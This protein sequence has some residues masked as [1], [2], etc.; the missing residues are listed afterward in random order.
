VSWKRELGLKSTKNAIFWDVAPCVGLV[1][2]DVS[3]ERVTSISRSK[4]IGQLTDYFHPED[5]SNT[6]L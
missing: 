4:G 1:T 6:F 2:S 5:G 3:E